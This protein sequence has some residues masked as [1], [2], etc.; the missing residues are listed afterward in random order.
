LYVSPGFRDLAD[1][2]GVSAL[3]PN[4]AGI[5]DVLDRSSER[6]A[7][8]R[9]STSLGALMLVGPEETAETSGLRVQ[10]VVLAEHL[11]VPASR[12]VTHNRT[13]GV[14]EIFEVAPNGL[15]VPTAEASE[16]PIAWGLYNAGRAAGGT[17]TEDL[18]RGTKDLTDLAGNLFRQ[19]A[20]PS[21]VEQAGMRFFELFASFANIITDNAGTLKGAADRERVERAKPVRITYAS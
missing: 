17:P 19:T 10:Q 5:T 7:T 20:G 6:Y 11:H 8:G 3:A 18:A 15:I 16:T 21:P 12:L 1:S 13:L 9:L 2:Q 4:Q 14:E